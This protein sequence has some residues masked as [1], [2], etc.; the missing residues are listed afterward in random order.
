ME[1]LS[2]FFVILAVGSLLLQGFILIFNPLGVN[3][4]AN[5][6]FGAFLIFWATFWTDELFQLLDILDRPDGLIVGIRTCQLLVP[7]LFYASVSTY[8]NPHKTLSK[9]DILHFLLPGLVSILLLLQKTVLQKL[10]GDLIFTISI[11][12]LALFYTTRSFLLI[13]KHEKKVEFFKSSLENNDLGWIK[14]II[15]ALIGISIFIL[16][17]NILFPQQELNVFANAFSLS[18]IFYVSYHALAQKEIYNLSKEQIESVIKVNE[19]SNQRTE[20]LSS[21]DL[22]SL[23]A[24]LS[25][26]MEKEK[27][28]LDNEL[29]LTKLA[30]AL[31][32][33]PHQLSFLLNEGFG[34]NFYQYV[35]SFRVDAAKAMLLNPEFAHLSILGLAFEAGF[36]SKSSF[37]T[38][39]KQHTGL[40]PTA[41]KRSQG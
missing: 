38:V 7:W 24:S 26:L 12:F 29:S 28:Y 19:S 37:N 39:F 9:N 13:K 25:G 5:T 21:A 14:K 27:P 1:A 31:N 2:S 36:N 23:K 33:T 10:N 3:K 18:I 17:Y 40:T 8:T 30:E 41:Y 32:I 6:F 15:L 4:R 11:L 16:A 34:Q 35:N 22:I 20:L